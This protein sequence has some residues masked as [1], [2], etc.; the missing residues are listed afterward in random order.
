MSILVVGDGPRDAVALPNVVLNLLGLEVPT[1]YSNWHN[2]SYLKGKGSAYKRKVKYLTRRALGRGCAALA[3]VVDADNAP[4]RE[5]LRELY[6]GRDEDRS[7]NPAFPTALGEAIPHFD[8]WL[9]DD[10]VAVR[11]G[12]N[13]GGDVEV[14]NAVKV[15]SPKEVLS[16]LI[17][18]CPLDNAEV[19]E[20]LGEIARCLCVKRCGHAKEIG[21]EG[22][23]KEVDVEIR[24]AFINRII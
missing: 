9:L 16:R 22:F 3:I 12:L 13:L 10:S 2:V 6:R 8:T 7:S 19:S 23:S 14:P 11:K 15:G 20:I 24:P 1:E 21:L 4:R 5:K 18:G 17:V